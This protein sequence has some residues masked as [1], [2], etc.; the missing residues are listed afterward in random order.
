MHRLS[1][2]CFRLL[3]AALPLLSKEQ[4]QLV[5]RGDLIRHYGEHMVTAK[6][7]AAPAALPEGAGQPSCLLLEGGR[8]PQGSANFWKTSLLFAPA[9]GGLPASAS[10]W[11]GQASIAAVERGLGPGCLLPLGKVSYLSPPLLLPREW[12]FDKVSPSALGP[13]SRGMSS[14]WHS[15]A[16]IHPSVMRRSVILI[17]EIVLSTVYAPH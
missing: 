3:G 13:L 9:T 1:Y 15:Q 5:M 2:L 17:T 16:S 6:V 4:L 14:Q 8:L 11:D 10:A 12:S 7:G